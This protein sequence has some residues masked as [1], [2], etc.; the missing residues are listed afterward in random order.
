MSEGA[1]V[2]HLTNVSY[3]QVY[4]VDAD[5]FNMFPISITEGRKLAEKELN[6]TH[7]VVMINEAARDELFPDGDALHKNIEMNGVPFRVAGVFHEK[8]QEESMFDGEYANPVLY[9]PKKCGR[10]LKDLTRRHRLRC[11][12]TLLSISKKPV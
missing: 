1:T 12:Q 9:V 11:R 8:K 3:P 4:G 6:S 10:L 7:Q 2:F 5:Y